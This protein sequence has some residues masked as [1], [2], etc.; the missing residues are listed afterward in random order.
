MLQCSRAFGQREWKAW[1]RNAMAARYGF[2]AVADRYQKHG[3]D[4]YVASYYHFA[5][6]LNQ[7]YEVAQR[8]V[9]EKN[10]GQQH[11]ERE[12]EGP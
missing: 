4:F 2:L 1:F 12:R 3:C 9:A 8:I 6:L 11:G 7:D 10:L 5:Y